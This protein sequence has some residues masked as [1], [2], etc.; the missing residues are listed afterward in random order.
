MKKSRAIIG[1]V[2]VFVLGVVCGVLAAHMAY[3]HRI[4]AFIS[5]RPQAKEEI[6][7]KRL[8]RKLDLDDRQL[9][10]VRGIVHKT[11]E[12]IRALRK[13]LRPQTEAIIAE[14]QGK[15]NALLTAEQQ[16]KFA[17]MITEHKERIQ[18]RAQE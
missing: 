12:E 8:A 18:K 10:Q 6:I 17:Q 1:V 3:M 2:L 14:A 16:R 7:V 15:I 9:E 11:Q 5:G 13:Q 4:E